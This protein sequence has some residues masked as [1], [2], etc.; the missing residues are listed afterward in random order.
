[1]DRGRSVVWCLWFVAS[2]W[3]LAEPVC[4]HEMCGVAFCLRRRH[5]RVSIR[6]GRERLPA[7]N[8]IDD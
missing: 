8:T 3:V 5:W 6:P 7:K 1:M 2:E 4:I